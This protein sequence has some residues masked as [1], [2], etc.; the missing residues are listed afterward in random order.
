MSKE[1]VY[2]ESVQK[3]S[4]PNSVDLDFGALEENF[5][6]EDRMELTRVLFQDVMDP[7]ASRESFGRD[8]ELIV[9]KGEG[10]IRHYF[11]P[12]IPGGKGDI[13]SIREAYDSRTEYYKS[14][15]RLFLRVG[16]G[17]MWVIPKRENPYIK[18]SMSECGAIIGTDND[19]IVVAHI[20]YSQ[21]D[22]IE[23]VVRFMKENGIALQNIYAVAS[24]G[25]QARKIGVEGS[26]R[27]K[28][29]TV[30]ANL[31]IPKENIST[32]EFHSELPY[33]GEGWLSVNITQVICTREAIYKYS[34]DLKSSVKL[35]S[36]LIKDERVSD[37]RNEKVI[38]L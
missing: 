5:A 14:P 30:Y 34:Y 20:S 10:D 25:N 27:A 36:S 32:F 35:G 17:E 13:N 4:K 26:K 29:I 18:I 33:G 2:S 22:E 24:V 7:P 3:E 19:R 6:V 21:I 8:T 12:D 37:Y 1:P 31:G 16:Q 9:G 38:K 11:L 28:D 23:A 15:E